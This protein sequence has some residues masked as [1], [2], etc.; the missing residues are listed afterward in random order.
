MLGWWVRAPTWLCPRPSERDR[1][2][3]EA[4]QGNGNE[5]AGVIEYIPGRHRARPEVSCGLSDDNAVAH[6]GCVLADRM[7]GAHAAGDRQL[8]AD[9]R[10]PAERASLGEEVVVNLAGEVL[11]QDIASVNALVCSP[12]NHRCVLLIVGTASEACEPW[13]PVYTRMSNF[14]NP[15]RD[16]TPPD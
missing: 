4:G 8:A 12:G 14:P 9:G 13:R 6:A 1:L 10:T 15:A 16:C 5:R 11:E 2:A 3:D 7:A